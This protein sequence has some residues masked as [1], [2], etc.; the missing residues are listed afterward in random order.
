MTLKNRLKRFVRG[1]L[2]RLKQFNLLQKSLNAILRMLN[3][4]KFLSEVKRRE[5]VDIFDYKTLSQKLPFYPIEKIK[6]SNY[7]G[8]V[9]SIKEFIGCP[10]AVINIE[11]GLYFDNIVSYY[12]HYKTYDTIM[13]FSDFRIDCIRRNGVNKRLLAI[14][15]YIHYATPLLGEDEFAK[16]KSSLGR[17]LLYLPSHSTSLTNGTSPDFEKEV[18]LIVQMQQSHHFDTVVV[19]VYFRDLNYK[20]CINMYLSKGFRITTAGHMYDLNFVRR[21]KS[22]ISLADMTASN[23]VGTNLGFCIHMGKPHIIICDYP[24]KYDVNRQGGRIGRQLSDC[25]R[26]YNEAITP[27]QYKLVNKYWGLDQVK[28][29][30]ELLTFLLSD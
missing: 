6:D 23:R 29:K 7:Y 4:R 30:E 22:I 24:T 19:C 8:Y 3:G 9:H 26:D 18:D 12:E 2:G 5:G 17:V 15:P 27:E 21:L 13:T 14:G 11:H 20:E 1:Q 28:T 25:F 10:D 16:L